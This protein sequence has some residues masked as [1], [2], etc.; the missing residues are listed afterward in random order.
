MSRKARLTVTTCYPGGC[1]S[2]LAAGVGRPPL[3][4][5]LLS[6]RQ[7]V[8]ARALLGVCPALCV[9]PCKWV[10]YLLWWV[11]VDFLAGVR[12]GG[13]GQGEP[14]LLIVGLDVGWEGCAVLHAPTRSP[15]VCEGPGLLLRSARGGCLEGTA[16]VRVAFVACSSHAGCP[17]HLVYFL[18]PV[19]I[20]CPP[21]CCARARCPP[22]RFRAVVSTPLPLHHPPPFLR[23]ALIPLQHAWLCC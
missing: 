1:L 10:G 13:D 15:R 2:P 17:S 9:L 3:G 19:V 22:P 21:G 23:V 6:G 12:M 11:R 8:D 16:G 20:P 14:G 18:A 4:W 7:E 5:R